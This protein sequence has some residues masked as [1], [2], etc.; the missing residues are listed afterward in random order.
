MTATATEL[1]AR[2]AIEVWLGFA[3]AP[4]LAAGV[5]E[6]AETDSFAIFD[7][8]RSAGVADVRRIGVLCST[9]SHVAVARAAGAGAVVAVGGAETLS[10]AAPDALV[11]REDLDTL[12]AARYGADGSQRRLVLL[13]PG[14]ALTSDAVKRAAAG[15]DLCHREPEFRELDRRIRGKLRTLAG[16][17]IDWPIALL[18]GSGTS[19]NEAALRAVVRPGRRLLVVVNGVYGERLRETARR[20]GIETIAVEGRWT[21]PIDVARVADALAAEPGLDALAVVH[22]ETTT[23][24][25]NPLAELAHAAAATGVLSVVDAISS[26][27]VE[28]VALG[29]GIDF[30]TCTSNKCL[31]GLPGAAFVLVSPAGSRRARSVEPSSV[32]LDLCAYLDVDVSGSPPFTPAIPAL[33]ALD[34]A[35]DRELVEGVAGRRARYAER[36]AIVDAA[37]GRLGLEQLVESST[38]SH[39]IRSVRLPDGVSFAALHERLRAAGFVIYAGQ[40]A[41]AAEIFRVACMGELEPSDMHGFVAALECALTELGT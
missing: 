33:A 29:D 12:V 1:A 3:P 39:S 18:S 26:F 5:V 34:V 21:E 31:H 24:L 28:E 20:A 11:A 40:G 15:T 7:A 8:M 6:L 13:N 10:A 35:L 4:P 16:V 37:F 14:P 19:A 2:P 17:G 38:R 9:P 23:G 41:L 36:C 30:M 25:L 27:G 22:H 32:A